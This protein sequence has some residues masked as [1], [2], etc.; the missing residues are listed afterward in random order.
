MVELHNSDSDGDVVL[1]TPKKS[2]Q[3]NPWT[4][5]KKEVDRSMRLGM[6][7]R[8]ERRGMFDSSDVEPIQS[9]ESSSESEPVPAQ[10]QTKSSKE[11]KGKKKLK[12]AQQA[13]SPESEEDS[14]PISNTAPPRQARRTQ[15]RQRSNSFEVS[16]QD[17]VQGE[18]E[19]EIT[20]RN[21]RHGQ[22]RK[23]RSESEEEQEQEEEGQIEDEESDEGIPR[24]SGRR[25]S[26]KTG[27]Q[28]KDDLDEDLEFLRSSPPATSRRTQDRP[29]NAR[30]KALAALKQRRAAAEP[31][32]SAATPGRKRTVVLSDSDDESESDLEIIKEEDNGPYQEE[33]DEDED[34]EE[35][36]E[37][38]EDGHRTNALDVFQ[39]NADDGDFINDD[40]DGLI[41]E[42]MDDA[43]L[44]LQFSSLGRAKPRELFKYAVDWMVQKKINPA[45][46]S[47]SEIYD[48]TFRKLDDE[49][50]GLASSKYSSSVWTPEFT[51]AL[52]ARPEIFI[53]EIGKHIRAVT[54]PHCEACNRRTHPA[55]FS[56]TFTGAPYNKETLEPIAGDSDSSSES[57]SDSDDSSS[58]SSEENVRGANTE[59]PTYNMQGELIA[60]ES[61][62]FDL[63]S[64]CKANAQVAHTLFH[65]RHH[66]NSWVVEYL[67]RKGHLKSEK[68][69]ER[70]K[71][72][73]RKREKQARKIVKAMEKE[74]KIKELHKLYKDQVEFA[75]E[76]KN[77]YNRGWGRRG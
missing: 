33:E 73:M 59:K 53:D 14:D 55:T 29:M 48:L 44:P 75:L 26:R 23:G 4:P 28:E 38:D 61:R 9:S 62:V 49:V 7:A 8:S 56:I 21:T 22:R 40:D 52:K 42:P 45:F 19:D 72:S 27:Q 32:S 74:G 30:Q 37:N 50:K 66:L 58:A 2:T 41:G 51:R 10:K 60:P 20:P 34:I 71:L 68:L 54:M 25:F 17:V 24:S 69:V 5:S 15:R 77:D 16:D 57:S 70:D 13:P 67:E 64:T 63:G 11:K 47:N 3:L 39:E 31:S 6:P 1:P 46:A 35:D 18:S 76:A 12:R 43:Q 36:E 65:W